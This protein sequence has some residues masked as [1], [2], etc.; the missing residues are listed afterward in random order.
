MVLADWRKIKQDSRVL[1]MTARRFRKRACARC[2]RV[3]WTSVSKRHY[4]CASCKRAAG[5]AGTGRHSEAK[6]SSMVVVPKPDITIG[7]CPCCGRE[8]QELLNGKCAD[9]YWYDDRHDVDA[10][11]S[12][13]ARRGKG[14]ANDFVRKVRS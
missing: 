7:T 3:S 14:G 2:S 11:L 13:R 9:Y 10:D 8:N 5:L 12:A 1:I 4:I 6:Y